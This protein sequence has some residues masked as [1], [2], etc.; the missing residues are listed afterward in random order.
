VRINEYLSEQLLKL[1]AAINSIEPSLSDPKEDKRPP[2]KER[3]IKEEEAKHHK[4]Q[5]RR[6]INRD[7]IEDIHCGLFGQGEH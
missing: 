7:P 2:A 1:L 5:R 6:E 4:D 3:P